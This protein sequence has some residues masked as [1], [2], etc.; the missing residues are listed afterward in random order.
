MEEGEHLKEGE[1]TFEV[2]KL[3]GGEDILILSK[4]AEK[5]LNE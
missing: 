1:H 3:S 4:F 5:K 2:E